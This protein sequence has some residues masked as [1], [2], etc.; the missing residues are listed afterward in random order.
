VASGGALAAAVPGPATTPTPVVRGGL[1]DARTQVL[2][3][4]GATAGA[5][6]GV[7]GP[8]TGPAR[9]MPPLHA[10]PADDDDWGQADEPG[11]PRRGRGKRWALLA[12]AL[13]LLVLLGGGAYYLIVSGNRGRDDT[14]TTPSATT[15]AGATGTFLDSS[16]YVGRPADE[17]QAELDQLGLVVALRIAPGD[18][19]D[20]TGRE[21]AADDVVSL[22]P[23]DTTV[24]PQSTV[25][26]YY[27]EEAYAPDEDEPEPTPEPTTEAPTTSAAPP[28][29]SAAPP[30][31]TTAVTSP[32]VAPSTSLGG[33]TVPSEDP[34]PSEPVDGDTGAAPEG[35][36]G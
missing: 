29:T 32:S 19:L 2:A 20:R 8:G 5:G 31:S 10:P 28:T 18:L 17:V 34:P 16:R 15:S 24:P 6:S 33:T 25:T 36:A 22:D 13:L 7:M 23:T 14:T 30:P 26:V 35:E 11:G 3:A 21:F 9:P 27:A 1:A 12:A 4:T